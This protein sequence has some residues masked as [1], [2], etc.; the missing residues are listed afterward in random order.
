MVFFTK[1]TPPLPDDPI[2]LLQMAQA[3]KDA[4]K[5]H[6]LL[7]EAEK[8]APENAD[9]QRALLLLGELYRRDGRTPNMRLIKC[10]LFH[11]FEHPEAHAEEEQR[12]MAREFFD[13]PQLQK[14]LSLSPDR[15][16][17]LREYL[18]DMAESYVEIFIQG[19]SSHFASVLGVPLALKRERFL[20]PPSA[21]VIRNIF[22]CPF[23]TER[24]QEMLGRS[25]YQAFYRA[26]HGHTEALDE[27]LGPE[28][29]GLLA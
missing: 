8:R 7:L 3:E 23:L 20:A 11:A 22:L 17:F 16:Q 12:E 6:A 29:C 13:H 24:E 26:V 14:C 28:L 15:E 5:K 27:A 1:K 25:F 2:R 21:D 9:I 10:W 18:K 19:D 4:A